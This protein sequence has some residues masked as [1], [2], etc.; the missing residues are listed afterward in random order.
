MTDSR[1][2]DPVAYKKSLSRMGWSMLVFIG[3]SFLFTLVSETCDPALV[4]PRRWGET[5]ALVIKA[6]CAVLSAVCYMAPFFLAGVFY[7]VLSRRTVT[8]QLDLRIRLPREFP[9]LILAGLAILSA[10]AVI[11]AAFCDLIGY[12]MPT[13]TPTPS[14]YNDPATVILYMTVALAPAFAEEFLFR[15]VIYRNL[16]PFGRAQAVVI[17]ALMFALMHQNIAQLF[18]T[19]LAG[20][21]LA[22]MY[23][24]TGSIW[25]SVF[26]HMFNNQLSVLREV[27][28]YGRFGETSV[29]YI[30][31]FDTVLFL[32]GAVSLVILMLYY[33]RQ[34][35]ARR[36]SAIEGRRI[37]GCHAEITEEADTPLSTATVFRSLINPGIITF[38]SVVY[39]TMGL[40]WLLFFIANL[41]VS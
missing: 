37:F 17:S 8:R 25:C 26:F 10:G 40:M 16:R 14:D 11:N 41:G 24:L 36:S 15:G 13:G 35:R 20:I 12:S 27:L 5:T 6:L 7:Y 30:N 39:V 18:Y 19:F 28:Y 32:L 23:E 2:L 38:V 31:V 21:A 29:P 1:T 9:L 22:L 33:T 3:L 4:D 34:A